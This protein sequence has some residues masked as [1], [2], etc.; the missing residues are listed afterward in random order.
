MTPVAALMSTTWPGYSASKCIDGTPLSVPFLFRICICICICI[1]YHSPSLFYFV[2]Q[3][4]L[5]Q[6]GGVGR[7]IVICAIQKLR[8]HP[9]S[10]LIMERG[11]ES[12]WKRSSSSVDQM[13]SLPV[14]KMFISES[15][16]NFHPM[17]IQ[18]SLVGRVLAAL[19]DL[20]LGVR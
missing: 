3:E 4:K 9:G 13:N 5:S 17:E 14:P 15:Q 10:P 16:T 11:K 20:P 19:K 6:S 2:P 8:P 12:L 1:F 7:L 18:C